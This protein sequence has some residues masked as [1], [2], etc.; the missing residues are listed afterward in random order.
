MSEDS[1]VEA[2]AHTHL[3]VSPS[4]SGYDNASQ[5]T[6]AQHPSILVPYETPKMIGL[7]SNTGTQERRISHQQDV[8]H[9]NNHTIQRREESITL[10]KML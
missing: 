10:M 1:C 8:Q 5:F 6:Q 7:E 3:K 2:D 9:V 4:R